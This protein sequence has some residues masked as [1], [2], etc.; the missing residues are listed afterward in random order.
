MRKRLAL[1]L[2]LCVMLL[3]GVAPARAGNLSQGQPQITV[4]AS[5]GFGETGAYLIGEWV[6]VRVTLDNPQGGQSLHVTVRASVGNLPQ[7]GVTYEREV[8]LPSPSRKEITLYVY[9]GNYTRNF[10]V[11]VFDGENQVASVEAAGDPFEPPTNLIVGVISSDSSLLNI[12]KG[13]SVGHIL[14]P[15]PSSYGYYGSTS[16]ST[17]GSGTATIAHMSL[18]DIPSVSQALDNLGALVLDDV[19]TGTLSEEQRG[20]IESWV[21]RGGTLIATY[22][23]GGGDTLAG[24]ENLSP[25]TLSGSKSVGSFASLGAYVGTD[26][27][28]SGP[29]TVGNAALKDDMAETSNVLASADNTPLLVERDL[30]QGQV[31]YLG[32]SLSLPPLKDWSGTVDLA[33]KLLADHDLRV[34]YGAFMRANSTYNYSGIPGGSSVF[35]TYGGLFALPG[36]QLPDAWLVAFFLVFYIIIIG[37]VNFIVL[38]RIKRVELAWV[39]IPVLVLLFSIVA[40]S[41]A[42]GSKGSDLVAIRANVI[43]TAEGTD[44]ASLS[45]HFG[46]YSPARRTYQLD[47]N[48]DSLMTEISAYGYYNGNSSNSAP[49]LGGNGTTSVRKVNIDTWSIRA[50]LAQH[51]AKLQSPLQ[52]DIEL[53]NNRITGKVTN[54]TNGPLEDVALVRGSETQYIGYMAPGESAD[55]SLD[56][57]STIFDNSSPVD[58]LPPPAGV[59][60]PQYGF[61]SGNGANNTQQ[62]IYSRKVELLSA[63]LYP[64]VSGDTPTDMKVTLIAWG[65][66]PSTEFDVPGYGTRTE[67]LNVW[68]SSATIKASTQARLD[69]GNVPFTM[70]VPGAQTSRL[71]MGK[72]G[73]GYMAGS[74]VT[75]QLVKRLSTTKNRTSA[76]QPQPVNRAYIPSASLPSESVGVE[77]GS[78]AEM[79]FR[80]PAGIKPKSLELS[81]IDQP[82]EAKVPVGLVAFNTRTKKWDKLSAL[83]LASNSTS[84]T[85]PDPAQ[86][87]APSGEVR[88]R[89]L[90]AQPTTLNGTFSMSLNEND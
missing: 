49:V 16:S 72:S 56:F 29:Y 10:N 75:F 68:T 32:T 45:Q 66:S 35:E 13:E 89:V 25:V 7:N 47:L 81:Y 86:Y 59:T 36:L 20:V 57:R 55:V 80:L 65:P 48:S 17:S 4:K 85:L 11:G 22:R 90:A 77:V 26:I 5:A 73:S 14:A 69:P 58:L 19:D 87:T 64:L 71:S 52:A 40:Y 44:Y 42:L 60:V 62:R 54:L 27:T 78:Y 24:L 41:L 50:F 43:Q 21:A 61:Y 37:P 18:S 53:G 31:V 30:G 28:G 83:N 70:Y 2:L 39:T 12:L 15:L 79:R 46:L 8:D 3:S 63:A 6:P 1:L 9:D 84:I 74:T 76:S 34:S 23:A 88:V 38:R 67:E 82:Q 51:T 33:K